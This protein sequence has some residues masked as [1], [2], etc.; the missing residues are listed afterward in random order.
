MSDI[1]LK[2]KDDLREKI[3]QKQTGCYANDSE[4]Y[5]AVGQL[6]SYFIS[7]NRGKKKPLSLA[8]PFIGAKNDSFIKSRLRALYKKYDYD[9]EYKSTKFKYM[10]AMAAG[11]IPNADVDSDMIIAGFLHSNLLYEKVEKS[12]NKE[13]ND[14]E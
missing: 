1:L 9:I 4:Y 2:I 7:R 13:E 8:K 6:V 12:E 11:Y 3:S 14:N 10:Y 5:F